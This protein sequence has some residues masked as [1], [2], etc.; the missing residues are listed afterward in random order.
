MLCPVCDGGEAGG[1]AGTCATC[2]GALIL[3]GRYTLERLLGAG[4][5]SRVYAA[6]DAE[7]GSLVAIKILSLARVRDWKNVELFRRSAAVLAGLAHPAIPKLLE[8]FE[9]TRSGFALYALV[10]ELIDGE[11]LAEAQK[12][13]ARFDEPGIRALAAELLSAL[14]YLHGLSPPVI[15]RD[16]KP[17]NLMR[18]RDGRLVVIDFD[19]VRDVLR[20][21]GGSTMSAGTP[22]YT[23]I[24]Q[25]AGEATPATDLYAMGVTLLVLLSR[26]SPLELRRAGEQ[27]L[28]VRGHTRVSPELT[29]VLEKLVEPEPQAR[30]QSAAEVVAA[31]AEQAPPKPRLKVVPP[32]SDEEPAPRRARSKPSELPELPRP[33]QSTSYVVVGSIVAFAIAG[34]LIL[35][36][37]PRTT[38]RKSVSVSTPSALAPAK[39]TLP[40]SWSSSPPKPAPPPPPILAK[41]LSSAEVGAIL[42]SGTWEGRVDKERAQL[43][44]TQAKRGK[45]SAQL[46]IFDA[47]GHARKQPLRVEVTGLGSLI[48]RGR[49]VEDGVSVDQTFFAD[50]TADLGS[51]V[52]SCETRYA[53]AGSSYV[54][55]HPWSATRVAV[56]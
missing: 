39:A 17:S 7:D 28:D 27:R 29:R 34:A 3:H 56:R 5:Q 44:V 20:P 9:E 23:P 37:S 35:S 15:H 13:G 40:S 6:R 12:Q 32:P 26:Q 30:Y 22:G 2:G 50:L 41:G 48:F 49:A 16:L 47:A 21:D 46:T 24:E 25:Y 38:R 45:L 36:Q 43:A 42:T 11:T 14:D 18:R 51:L 54:V 19:L 10:H 31:L 8:Y 33:R 52:G 1:A 53:S 4:G 55:D